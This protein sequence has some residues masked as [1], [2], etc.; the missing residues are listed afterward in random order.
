VAEIQKTTLR[1]R[2]ER[3]RSS[4]ANPQS[5]VDYHEPSDR[6]HAAFVRWGS[7]APE[8]TAVSSKN[9]ALRI[10]ARS[11]FW[12]RFRSD[13]L[14]RR[15]RGPPHRTN[16]CLNR[17]VPPPSGPKPLVASSPVALSRRR[18]GRFEGSGCVQTRNRCSYVPCGR[19]ERC[20]SRHIERSSRRR[21][22]CAIGRLRCPRPQ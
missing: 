14:Y 5:D 21:A 7:G 13:G 6:G 9:W 11:E 3:P 16:G 19:G 4:A 17:R 10:R 2:R 12:T 15:A 8:D 22:P 18:I 20:C 1:A